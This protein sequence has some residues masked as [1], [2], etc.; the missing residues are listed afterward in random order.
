MEKKILIFDFD[1]TLADTQ[2]LI[3]E[4]YNAYALR[5]G[6]PLVSKEDL[7]AM[8][9]ASARDNFNKIN[10]S[11]WRIP[12]L[13]W[14]VRNDIRSK[15]SQVIIDPE[16]KASLLALHD[17][18]HQL[19]I[20]SSNSERAI[21]GFLKSNSLTIFRGVYSVFDLFGKGKYLTK[22]IRRKK[23]NKADVLYIGDEIRDMEA[24]KIAGIKPILVAWG[25]NESAAMVQAGAEKVV[26]SPSD[27][28]DL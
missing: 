2:D 10:I 4:S 12:I 17:H 21:N 5:K 11:F 7:P 14:R 20:V 1:G 13:V 6:Y 9:T 16:I 25:Y 23:W 3:I 19:Y 28:K 24:A 18:G 27:L 8:R 15:V 26:L 22:L